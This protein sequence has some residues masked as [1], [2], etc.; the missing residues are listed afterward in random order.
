MRVK[1]PITF[2]AGGALLLLAA[3]AVAG[4][5]GGGNSNASSGPPK[6]ASGATA[7]VGVSNEGLGN[8]LVN[9]Q[10]RTLYLFT[11]DSGTMSECSGACAVNWPPLR[12]TGKPT[13]GSGANA[14]LD[15]DD[16][17]VGR[18]AAGDLQRPS[19]LP[20]QG[21]QQ[22][23]RHQRPGSERVRRQLVRALARRR[24]G[25]RAG[26]RAQEAA[27]ATNPTKIRSRPGGKG[28]DRRRP[29]RAGRRP[30]GLR[31]QLVEQQ[32][33]HDGRAEPRGQSAIAPPEWAANTDALARPQLRPL[34]HPRHHEH[35]H[36]RDERREAEARVEVQAPVRRPVR[37]VR[38]EPDRPQRRRLHPGPRLERLRAEP[39][40]RRGD[41]EAPVQVATP[42]GG[43]NGLALGYGMLFGATEGSAFA[44]DPKTGK[45]LW[46]HKL[47]GNKHEGIDMAP[48]L[49]DNTVL[50]STIPGNASNFYQ[51]GALGIVYSL[52]ADTGKTMWKFNTIKDGA[53]LLGHPK[54]NSGGGL[55]YPPSVDS[56]GRVFLSVA[57][58]AP[59]YGTPSS[60]TDR[61]VP[62]PT[63]TPTRSSPSTADRQARS[64]SSRSPRT[65]C[66][67]TTCRSRRSSRSR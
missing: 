54:V 38:L 46:M 35:R 24:P 31:R 22:P 23:R 20:L 9:S 55:W 44:L 28:R 15:L 25:L 42:S 63:S 64:G 10:G 43:P 17:P 11:R 5:G 66:A 29:P 19:A 53:K 27:V 36:Q 7:T 26:R 40:D 6:T 67:T 60:R 32:R 57:N 61:A 14:S 30:R 51:G 3:L 8:I 47:T 13:I 1:R 34:E 21:R 49:Y 18:G 45:Q 41:V 62:D 33:H 52:D 59:L 39:A 12:A 16:Q 50:V 56:H 48:Q 2:P 58:P 4:C 65:T 37:G